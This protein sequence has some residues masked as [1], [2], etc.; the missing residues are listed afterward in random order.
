MSAK[1]VFASELTEVTSAAKDILGD[2]RYEQAGVFK[3]ITFISA[4][5]GVAGE[6][7]Y[8]VAATGYGAN[9]CTSVVS[10]SDAIGC[11]VLQAAMVTG[12]F[13]WVQIKGFATL[14]IAITGSTGDGDLLTTTG[15]ADGSLDISATAA[16]DEICAVAA[17][18]SDNE[19][20][21][22]FKF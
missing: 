14:S 19:I 13:G 8:Y 22:D 4:T 15:A 3:Y 18:E 20:M 7:A 11:G 1:T 9:S 16:T 5:A 21:C 10:E 6:V 17:N 2:L 12:E